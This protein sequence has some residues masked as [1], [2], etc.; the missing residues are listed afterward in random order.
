MDK[1]SNSEANNNRQTI[2]ELPV[3]LSNLQHTEL[4]HLEIE[5]ADYKLLYPKEKKKGTN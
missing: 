2:S 1:K 4:I 3:V 5:F